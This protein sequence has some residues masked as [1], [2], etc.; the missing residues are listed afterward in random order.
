MGGYIPVAGMGSSEFK[1]S[2]GHFFWFSKRPSFA[3]FRRA[4]Q[5]I[6]RHVPVYRAVGID[7]LA[8]D[9]PRLT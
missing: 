3:A 2:A 4:I 6:H 8:E 1:H 9:A 5:S 7:E